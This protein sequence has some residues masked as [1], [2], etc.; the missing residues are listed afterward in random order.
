MNLAHLAEHVRP[1]RHERVDVEQV[2]KP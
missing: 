2:A 1:A